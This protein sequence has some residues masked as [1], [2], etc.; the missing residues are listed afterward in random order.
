M[1]ICIVCT[2]ASSPVN[3]Y[4]CFPWP[5][6][7]LAG[8]RSALWRRRRSDTDRNRKYATQFS[9]ELPQSCSILAND[10]RCGPVRGVRF[11]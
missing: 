8:K 1:R 3:K 11:F 4:V 9:D 2:L 10:Q 7:K 6:E 5:T